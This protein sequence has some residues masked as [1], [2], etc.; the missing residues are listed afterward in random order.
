[1]G[2]MEEIT[3]I[4]IIKIKFKKRKFITLNTINQNTNYSKI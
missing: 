3:I 2:T 4:Q 1:M